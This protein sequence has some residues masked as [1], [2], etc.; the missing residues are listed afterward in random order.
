MPSEQLGSNQRE[1]DV[2]LGLDSDAYI[3]ENLKKYEDVKERW[4]NS[5]ME[6]WKAGG[7][8]ENWTD[9][10]LTFTG[11]TLCFVRNRE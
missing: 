3:N 11:L 4:A 2:L 7:Q 10:P 9:Q 6:E 8:G 1:L 5:S